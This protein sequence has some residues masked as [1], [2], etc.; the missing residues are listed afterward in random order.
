LP[1]GVQEAE[2][3]YCL[4]KA[5]QVLDAGETMTDP[6]LVGKTRGETMRRRVDAAPTW[7]G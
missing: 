4:V 3:S 6:A 5:R 1:C 7:Y 2:R